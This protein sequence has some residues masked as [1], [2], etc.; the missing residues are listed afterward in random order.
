M[1]SVKRLTAGRVSGSLLSGFK[2]VPLTA[3]AVL[4]LR[5]QLLL[6][7]LLVLSKFKVCSWVKAV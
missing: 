2:V 5:L 6:L 4:L 3:L 1:V 7:L